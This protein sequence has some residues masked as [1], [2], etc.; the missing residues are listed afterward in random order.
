MLDGLTIMEPLSK[1]KIPES[2]GIGAI[3]RDGEVV[4]PSG[5]TALGVDDKVYVFSPPKAANQ[6][7][8][9]FS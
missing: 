5:D 3:I 4:I 2:I 8:K 9:L 7:A 6:A 1:A